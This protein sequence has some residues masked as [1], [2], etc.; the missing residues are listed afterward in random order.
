MMGADRPAWRGP[1]AA[2]GGARYS[3]NTASM[4]CKFEDIVR[5]ARSSGFGGLE[6]W[7]S[8]IGETMPGAMVRELL[9]SDGLEISAFQLLRDFEGSPDHL[10]SER[11]AEAERL[12]S[13]MT[14]V[15]AHT[16]LLC[17]NT[18][19][20]CS[21]D[22]HVITADLRMLADMA[23]DRGLSVALEPLVWSKRLNRYEDALACV[24]ALDHPALGLMVDSLHWFWAGTPIE[25]A[26]QIPASKYLG[27][28]VCNVER[29]D[30]PPLQ[31]ARHHRLFP[32][33]G[34]W[35]ISDLMREVRAAG[36][37]GLINFEVFNDA[38]RG[39]TAAEFADLAARSAAR[40]NEAIE[41]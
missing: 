34:I 26:R 15:G 5:A 40:L 31:V 29:C 36:Y 4:H 17:A 8:D 41:N 21:T 39:L 35:P 23:K 1:P 19:E 14:E 20:A 13:Q 25:F 30:L 6:I 22:P 18:S 38:F 28:Q 9:A 32:C 11:L 2:S 3:L 16:L 27:M 10:R 37:D 7:H 24:L 33:E 12:M